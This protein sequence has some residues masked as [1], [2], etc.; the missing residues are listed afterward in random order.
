[1][2]VKVYYNDCSNIE[3]NEAESNTRIRHVYHASQAIYVKCQL[4]FHSSKSVTSCICYENDVTVA[5]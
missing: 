5:F 2:L 1:M 4:T 3:Q